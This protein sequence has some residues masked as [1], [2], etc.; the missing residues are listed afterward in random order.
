M[1]SRYRLGIDA[2][3]VRTCAGTRRGVSTT[4]RLA[5]ARQGV[6]KTRSVRVSPDSIYQI[7]DCNAGAF[8][9]PSALASRMQAGGH[10]FGHSVHKSRRLENEIWNSDGGN[11]GRGC[12]A[13]DGHQRERAEELVASEGVRPGFRL[14]EGCAVHAAAQGRE[15]LEH[16]R[17]VPAHEGHLLGRG[18]LRR[19]RR[20][21]ADGRQHDALRGRRLREP[22]Q[23]T[24][25]VRRLHGRQ[26]RRDRGRPDL[27]SRSRQE[28]RRGRQGGQG[29]SSARSTR[30]PRPR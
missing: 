21:Q 7:S 4:L 20:S 28:V 24:V 14:A 9:L 8:L 15:G 12:R 13:D 25:A 16:L 23:A 22:A 17:A 10:L 27:R 11:C 30:C 29:S 6:S 5:R 26:L 1:R 18:R 19:R 2:R 3:G